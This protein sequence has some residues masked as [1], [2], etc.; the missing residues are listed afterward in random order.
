MGIASRMT[1]GAN[2]ARA[3][4][5][6]VASLL[7]VAALA[8]SLGPL[9]GVAQARRVR[10]P[11]TVI[12]TGPPDRTASRTVTFAFT[13]LTPGR[14]VRILRFQYRVDRGRWS[15]WIR[16][17]SVSLRRL[18]PGR[19]VFRV[20]AQD[21]ARHTDRTPAVG[22]FVVDLKPPVL[23][24]VVAPSGVVHDSSSVFRVAVNEAST[25]E[26]STDAAAF[27]PCRSRLTVRVKRNG[28]HN[29][30]VRATD[31][32]GNV[33]KPLKCAWKAVSYTHLTLPT[34]REV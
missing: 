27:A 10:P 33:S 14:H 22:V 18:R 3:R 11:Q 29:F 6:L 23:R 15:H 24:F 21:G 16:R 32:A 31:L 26:C 13:A 12:Q 4:C 28:W 7:S 5:V 8:A 17:S 20:R 19:H 25:L 34:N 2:A 1:V 30:R 9:A